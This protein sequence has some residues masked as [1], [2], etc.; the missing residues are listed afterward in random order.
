M[1]NSYLLPPQGTEGQ[2]LFSEEVRDFN[3]VHI[4]EVAA[5]CSIFGQPILHGI[6]S[7]IRQLD[8]LIEKGHL[9]WIAP[10]T[11]L[12][13]KVDYRQPSYPSDIMRL[14]INEYEVGK[15]KI[16]IWVGDL[17]IGQIALKRLDKKIEWLDV[18]AKTNQSFDLSSYDSAI[19]HSLDDLKS[20]DEFC[21]SS[22]TAGAMRLTKRYQS[23]ASSFGTQRL[24]AIG[25]LSS[26]VGMVSPGLYSLF[27]GFIADLKAE[28]IA[29]AKTM[30]F[31][32]K[33]TNIHS[34]FRFVNYI[35]QS[36]IV[37][38][39][40]ETVSRP[41][42]EEQP[43]LK[44]IIHQ[45]KKNNTDLPNLFGKTALVIGGSRGVGSTTVKLLAKAGAQ[46]TFTY[47]SSSKSAEALVQELSS[48]NVS[49]L[50]EDVLKPRLENALKNNIKF[51]QMYFFATP[52]IFV[53]KTQKY[54][55]K[56]YMR[57][58]N[59]Y[60]D[61][62]MNVYEQ[63][64]KPTSS[65]FY[66]SS[67]AVESDDLNTLEYRLAKL[68]GEELCKTLGKE[69]N[70]QTFVVKRLPRLASDQTATIQGGE[71]ADVI[72]VFSQILKQMSA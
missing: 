34:E 66:P 31:K 33:T 27:V 32:C 54:D 65:I 62:F 20:L 63:Y 11:E 35:A 39:S 70:T 40:L 10:S 42:P 4:D 52:Q 67:I 28:P 2:T 29:A 69:T 12:N 58:I 48:Y 24:F 56:L 38:A 13:I 57:F 71:N 47:T 8:L 46:V 6:H 9:E 23:A 61:G 44:E 41:R 60:I 22:E 26:L 49:A 64:T 45:I 59:F 55:P 21:V 5:R 51:D 50:K 53:R 68:A 72:E 3:P 1:I 17:K 43:S 36:D 14:E 19:D 7:T 30:D 18:E 16:S 15:A 25:L 37:R